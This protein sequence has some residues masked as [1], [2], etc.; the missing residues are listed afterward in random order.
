M[1]LMGSKNKETIDQNDIP[2]NRHHLFFQ[3]DIYKG[4][5]ERRFRNHQGLVIPVLK[6]AHKEL[7]AIL[8]PPPKPTPDMMQ[9]C[10]DVLSQDLI[11][12]EFDPFFALNAVIDYLGVYKQRVDD[13][14][15]ATHAEKIRRHLG[16]QAEILTNNTLL[17]VRRN[18]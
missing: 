6:S 3:K 18:G 5:F 8:A 13:L 17:E 9:G 14:A 11:E 10:L 2:F 15:L 16:F 4:S 7:H 1:A 12:L